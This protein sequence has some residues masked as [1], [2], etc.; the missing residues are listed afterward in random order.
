[1]VQG[2]GCM[3]YRVYGLEFWVYGLGFRVLVFGFRVV[4]WRFPTTR[5]GL[6]AF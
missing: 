6:V 1:M 4:I 2:F 3:D 5:G